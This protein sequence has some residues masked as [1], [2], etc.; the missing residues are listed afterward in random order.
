LVSK[1]SAAARKAVDRAVEL[2][3]DQNS[4]DYIDLLILQ[5][6]LA[7]QAEDFSGAENYY[8]E[9]LR[10]NNEGDSERTEMRARAYLQLGKTLKKLHRNEEARTSLR[11]AAK[12]WTE[13]H[14]PRAAAQA[15]LELYLIEE[16]F[17]AKT[18]GFL[19]SLPPLVASTAVRIHKERVARVPTAASQRALDVGISY[20]QQLVREATASIAIH[21]AD[22]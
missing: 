5:G 16:S 8:R 9:A 12:I 4:K 13:L 2:I 1:N 6:D 10:V 22:W 20:W 19:R 7:S 3:T 14:E 17:S 11:K 18:V 21:Y 15:Q